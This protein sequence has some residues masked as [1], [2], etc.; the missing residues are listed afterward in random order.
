[1]VGS[2]RS[3]VS[4][5]WYLFS[6]QYHLGREFGEEEVEVGGEKFTISVLVDLFHS[7]RTPVTQTVIS[8]SCKSSH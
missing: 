8:V 5:L 7:M 3:P 2:H 1:M 4:S 6:H